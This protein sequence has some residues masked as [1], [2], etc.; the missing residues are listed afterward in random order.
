M[1][2]GDDDT[3]SHR[4]IDLNIGYTVGLLIYYVQ[5]RLVNM[6]ATAST[7]VVDRA[8]TVD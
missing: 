8:E 6:M 7:A 3:T 4:S 5:C 2:G 1:G